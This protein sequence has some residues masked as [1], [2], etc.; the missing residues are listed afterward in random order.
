[1]GWVSVPKLAGIQPPGVSL[2][3]P[4][5]LG[6]YALRY[7][8]VM[9]EQGRNLSPEP[10]YGNLFG[11]QTPLPRTHN[12]FFDRP[13]TSLVPASVTWFGT[14]HPGSVSAGGTVRADAVVGTA[15]LPSSVSF[16]P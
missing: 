1:P 11:R 16:V 10:D 12:D 14:A 6:F 8:E 4:P 7:H 3:I 9:P 15:R 2:F 13:M 5:S